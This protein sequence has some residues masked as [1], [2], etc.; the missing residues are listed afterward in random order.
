MYRNY[1]IIQPNIS[2]LATC[3]DGIKNQGELYVDCGGP[4]HGMI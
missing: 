3:T 4:C 2:P 1:I